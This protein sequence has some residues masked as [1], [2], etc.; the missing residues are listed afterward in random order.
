MSMET[1]EAIKG[2]AIILGV[3]SPVASLI[4]FFG[5]V[6]QRIKNMESMIRTLLTQERECKESREAVEDKLHD[7]CTRLNTRLSY[8][9]GRQNGHGA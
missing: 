8:L 3:L 5:V 1:M 6:I 4:F 2:G 7:R 9:E